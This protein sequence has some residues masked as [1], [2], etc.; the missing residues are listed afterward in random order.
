MSFIGWIDEVQRVFGEVRVQEQLHSKY[1]NENVFVARGDKRRFHFKFSDRKIMR[2]DH[3]MSNDQYFHV[4][5]IWPTETKVVTFVISQLKETG[6]VQETET[7]GEVIIMEV[8]QKMLQKQK[9]EIKLEI[10]EDLNLSH[11]EIIAEQ[12]DMNKQLMEGLVIN[13]GH[14]LQASITGESVKL[15]CI[16]NHEENWDEEEGKQR[17]RLKPRPLVSKTDQLV[18]PKIII[19][20]DE[21]NETRKVN[22]EALTEHKVSERVDSLLKKH[23]RLNGSLNSRVSLTDKI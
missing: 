21:I 17:R 22:V 16:R 8:V 4:Q 20:R 15:P 18:K 10:Q 19:K 7:R 14:M 13:L 23:T 9:Q 12:R 3:R 6:N 11:F 5:S 1:R 2:I